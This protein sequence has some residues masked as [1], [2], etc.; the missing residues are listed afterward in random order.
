MFSYSKYAELRDKKEM[1]DYEVAKRTGVQTSTLSNW[2]AGRY[3]PKAD[4]IRKIADI[5]GCTLD[6]LMEEKEV[7]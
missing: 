7:V 3:I 1:T 6:D 2:K 5:L 4:K